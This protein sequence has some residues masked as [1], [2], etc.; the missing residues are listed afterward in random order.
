MRIVSWLSL[1]LFLCITALLIRSL[2][3]TDVLRLQSGAM[4]RGINSSNGVLSFGVLRN[5]SNVAGTAPAP[6]PFLGP[7]GIAIF[8]LD[9]S[10]SPPTPFVWRTLGFNHRT[11]DGWLIPGE[12]VHSSEWAIPYWILVVLFALLPASRL[13]RYL[14]NYN[15]KPG[16]CRACNYDLRAHHPGDKCPECGTLIPDRPSAIGPPDKRNPP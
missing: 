9:R 13:R 8:H 3:A 2:W 16:H 6:V 5:T 1:L 12:M 15:R 14:K 7:D 11:S 4:I 10:D